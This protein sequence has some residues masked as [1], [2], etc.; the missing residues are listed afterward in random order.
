MQ[1]PEYNRRGQAQLPAWRGTFSRRGA[2]DLIEIGKH[3]PRAHEKP[4]PGL[5]DADGARRA[6]ENS[7]PEPRFKFAD[8]A[9]DG[10]GRAP[11]PPRG[12]GET[13]VLGDFIEDSHSIEP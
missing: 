9:R 11:E 10:G 3:V 6:V 4:I 1:A 7:H 5:G 12:F 13:A 2:F 8:R